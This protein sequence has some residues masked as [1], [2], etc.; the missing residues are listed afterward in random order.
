MLFAERGLTTGGVSALLIVW[1]AVA[2]AL[3]VPSGAWADRFSRTKLLAIAQLLRAVGYATWWLLQTPTGFAIGFVLWGVHSALSSG[4]FQAL[5]YDELK[6]GGSEHLYARTLGRAQALQLAANTVAAALAA[7]AVLAGFRAVLLASVAVSLIAGGVIL[8]MPPAPRAGPTGEARYLQH[9]RQGVVA[10]VRSPALLGLVLGFG[11]V[12]AMAGS[13]EEFTPLYFRDAGLSISWIGVADAGLCAAAIVGS[14]GAARLAKRR[15]RL[16]V[17]LLGVGGWVLLVGG[18][19][20]SV[21]S[22]IL[23]AAFLG[24]M[25]ALYVVWD[26]RLQDSIDVRARATVMSVGGFVLELLA[27]LSVAVFGVIGDAF[28]RARAFQVFGAVVVF[29]AVLMRL[30]LR[31]EHAD[32]AGDGGAADDPQDVQPHLPQ[33]HERG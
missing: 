1:S 16:N 10:A 20:V 11:F 17:V 24:L 2:F 7:I 22:W 27:I 8:T 33:H 21:G 18:A 30:V 4:T 25:Q 31:E 32:G 19:S 13:I 5:I 6:S 9:L 14:V 26:T 23:L 15:L 3:E 12:G 28:G 29:G